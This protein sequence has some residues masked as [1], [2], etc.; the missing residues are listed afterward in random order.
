MTKNIL[1]FT[2]PCIIFFFI[3]GNTKSFSQTNA[4][5][6][7]AVKQAYGNAAASFSNEQIAWLINQLERSKVQKKK[8]TTGETIPLLSNI[9]LMSKFI[10]AL[11]KDD[12][13]NPQSINPL[14][15]NIDFFNVKKFMFA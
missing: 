6:P 5:I 11:Q 7:E 4:N 2:I 12:F 13:S 15:Y 14:K 10:P 8:L 9:S 1:R 3:L